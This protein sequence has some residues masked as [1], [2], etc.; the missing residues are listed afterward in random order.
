MGMSYDEYWNGDIELCRYYREAYKLRKKER[1]HDMWLQGNYIYEALLCAS[2]LFHDLAPEGTT[3]HSYRE[4]PYDL[5]GEKEQREK[6][7]ENN[8]KKTETML[9]AWMVAVNKKRGG[10]NG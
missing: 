2:P 4:A 5:F 7:I 1:N 3:A 9:D 8:L 6:L 10:D